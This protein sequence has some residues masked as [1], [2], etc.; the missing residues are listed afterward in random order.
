MTGTYED[1]VGQVIYGEDY[2][3]WKRKHHT[4]PSGEQME[5]YEASKGLHAKHDKNAMKP[6]DPSEVC[7]VDV[8]DCALGSPSRGGRMGWRSV[9]MPKLEENSR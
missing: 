1:Y 8:D 3:E 2:A 5:K 7:C 6:V 9:P 4:K